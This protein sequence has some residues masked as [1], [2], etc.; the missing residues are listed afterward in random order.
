MSH[1]VEKIGG[2]MTSFEEEFTHCWLVAMLPRRRCLVVKTRIC[3]S[4]YEYCFVII[5]AFADDESQQV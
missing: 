2:E 1:I 5:A 3:L 4:L